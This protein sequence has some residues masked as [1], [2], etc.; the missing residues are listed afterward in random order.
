MAVT[1]EASLD[2]ALALARRL[3][4]HDQARLI[5]QVAALLAEVPHQAP[6]PAHD[7]WARW[8][9]LRADI[10][11]HFPDAHPADRLDQDRRERDAL[12]QHPGA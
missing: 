8:V 3:T 11:A 9:Q 12:L 7:A 5:A 6:S 4:P 10:A 1:P 2:Q